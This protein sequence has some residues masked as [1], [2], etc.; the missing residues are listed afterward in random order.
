MDRNRWPESP[1]YAIDNF[2]GKLFFWGGFFLAFL[3]VG[4]SQLFDVIDERWKKRA[5]F[6]LRRA[7]SGVKMPF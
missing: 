4:P 1:E 7:F 5:V 2:R 6:S 3:G